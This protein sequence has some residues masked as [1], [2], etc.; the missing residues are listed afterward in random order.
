LWQSVLMFAFGLDDCVT[1]ALKV[2]AHCPIYGGIVWNNSEENK[3]ET[4]W[5][6]KIHCEPSDHDSFGRATCL[7]PGLKF[8]LK[9]YV[10]PRS[11]DY[12]LSA[13]LNF[14]TLKWE[15]KS[16]VLKTEN[17]RYVWPPIRILKFFRNLLR[18]TYS[19]FWYFVRE[20]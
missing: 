13:D 17:G 3:Y 7:R 1:I 14:D 15:F 12:W 5:S 20:S 10:W 6:S 19:S 18:Q 2:M 4:K 11:L 16:L 8:L 9:K